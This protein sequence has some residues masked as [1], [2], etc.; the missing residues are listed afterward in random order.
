[1]FSG[2]DSVKIPSRHDRCV[3][4]YLVVP[5]QMG[6]VHFLLEDELVQF[7]VGLAMRVTDEVIEILLYLRVHFLL[8]LSLSGEEVIQLQNRND[9][10]SM[11]IT[12]MLHQVLNL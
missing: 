5:L 12:H 9:M 8:G 3:F 11:L 1:M 7:G 2:E 6:E 4:E 10:A